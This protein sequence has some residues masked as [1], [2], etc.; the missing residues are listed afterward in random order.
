MTDSARSSISQEIEHRLH[1]AEAQLQLLRRELEHT[2]R[3]AT[4]GTLAAGIAHEV[5]NLLTPLLSYAQLAKSNPDDRELQ[6]KAVD[7][8]LAGADAASKILQAILGFAG[9]AQQATGADVLQV[10]QDALTCLPRSPAKDGIE[11]AIHIQPGVHVRMHPLSLQQ[12]MLNL[13]LNACRVMRQTGGELKLT[14]VQRGDGSVIIT[15]SDTGP[16]IP[17]DIVGRL[18]EPFATAAGPKPSGKSKKTSKSNPGAEEHGTGLGLSICRQLV[19]AVGGTISVNTSPNTGAT[20][21]IILQAVQS[22]RAQAG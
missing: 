6:A 1:E 19:E 11:V 4:I 10:A 20:F 3:L 13:I 9:P 2:Q 7:R 18:F 17:A 16:G 21:T 14:G 15:V 22:E 12:V 8:T 5:N